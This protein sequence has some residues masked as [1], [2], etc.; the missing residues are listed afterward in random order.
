MFTRHGSIKVSVSRTSNLCHWR[1]VGDNSVYFVFLTQYN[2][3]TFYNNFGMI[4]LF[5]LLGLMNY[6]STYVYFILFFGY[7]YVCTGKW[8]V[9]FQNVDNFVI[10]HSFVYYKF[11]IV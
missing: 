8:I 4:I 7:L 3:F 9:T 11:Y 10:N 6:L 2:Y 5:F 1:S